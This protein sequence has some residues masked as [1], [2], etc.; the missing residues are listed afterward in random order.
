MTLAGAAASVAMYFLPVAMSWVFVGL[1]FVTSLSFE[2]A[3][4]MYN[5]FLPEIADEKSMNRVSA[6]GFA[7]GYVGG[8]LALLIGVLVVQFGDRIGLP[9]EP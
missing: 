8:G 3:W 7:M 9:I 1:F 2:L 4:G 5:A 6:Y